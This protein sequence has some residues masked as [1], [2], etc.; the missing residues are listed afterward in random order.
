MIPH[1]PGRRVAIAALLAA[2]LALAGCGDP[3][4]TSYGTTDEGSVNGLA[5]LKAQWTSTFQSR[6]LY[7]L[8]TRLDD[9]DLILH[10]QR[11]RDLP[12]PQACTWIEEWLYAADGRQFVLVLRDGNV[13]PWLCR[14]WAAEARREALTA[15]DPVAQRLNTLAARLESRAQSEH[16]PVAAATCPL[17]TR[18][19]I[20]DWQPQTIAG[21][22]PATA[23]MRSEPTAD[24]AKTLLRA[25]SPDGR[26][27]AW[28]I[29]VPFGSSRL[30][31][32]AN[33]TPVL[34]AALVDPE[35]RALMRT[36]F[37]EIS[38]YR[39]L[40][41]P[42]V[43]GAAWV[44]SLAVREGD[45]KP[46]NILAM[47]FGTP[48]FNYVIIHALALGLAFLAWKGAW[49]GRIAAPRADA[50]ERFSRHVEALALQ[51][52]DAGAVAS[53]ANAIAINAGRALTKKPTD[54][55]D[56]IEQVTIATRPQTST[57]AKRKEPK[58]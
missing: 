51:L 53:C 14:R 30:V 17:F 23:T 37:E 10:V 58:P 6:T 29:E 12:G 57:Y 24:L 3:L 28:A 50:D 40:A 1:P 39:E 48:P 8:S 52:R 25:H 41:E 36:W 32:V 26:D 55:A 56:A 13:A 20:G 46:P 43:A 19:L 7:R 34:D 31:V 11:A 47:L 35:A 38:N 27:H 15:A 2:L 4:V 42:T 5:V 18:A 33:A 49:L 16:E 44:E 22:T 9:R 21:A 45:P 54:V